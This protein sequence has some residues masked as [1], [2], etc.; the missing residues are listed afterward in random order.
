MQSK[1]A[2][3]KKELE[4]LR[5]Q[6]AEHRVETQ[7]LQRELEAQAATFDRQVQQTQQAA[8]LQVAG[9]QS[10]LNDIQHELAQVQRQ[11]GELEDKLEARTTPFVSTAATQTTA[12]VMTGEAWRRYLKKL[13]ETCM[14]HVH[15]RCESWSSAITAALADLPHLDTNQS[16]TSRHAH[17]R[18][19]FRSTRYRRDKELRAAV[20]S[21]GRDIKA[22]LKGNKA[23]TA[24]HGRERAFGP[25]HAD[26]SQLQA[27]VAEF[28]EHM[29][30]CLKQLQASNQPMDAERWSQ[31]E[32]KLLTCMSGPLPPTTTSP[33][34]PT[35]PTP[36]SPDALTTEAKTAALSAIGVEERRMLGSVLRTAAVNRACMS[37][38][39]DG[40]ECLW[41]GVLDLVACLGSGLVE[42][43]HTSMPAGH[44]QPPSLQ[45]G[46]YAVYKGIS[47]VWL[48]LK[49][50]LRSIQETAAAPASSAVTNMTLFDNNDTQDVE[51]QVHELLQTWSA[52]IAQYTASQQQE[53]RCDAG[54]QTSPWQPRMPACKP[55]SELKAKLAAADKECQGLIDKHAKAQQTIKSLE[56]RLHNK[57]EIAGQY[58]S[59]IASLEDERQKLE[60]EREKL[61]SQFEQVRR[62]QQLQQLKVDHAVRE[63]E[64]HVADAARLAQAEADVVDYK[65]KLQSVSSRCKQSEQQVVNLQHQLAELQTDLDDNMQQQHKHKQDL[66]H[67]ER[68]AAKTEQQLKTAEEQL[69]ILRKQLQEATQALEDARA[70]N[71]DLQRRHDA[72][73]L[74]HDDLSAHLQ[75]ATF[76]QQPEHASVNL[77]SQAS[78]RANLLQ[79]QPESQLLHPA[80]NAPLHRTLPE[81]F[82]SRPQL[83][84][85]SEVTTDLLIPLDDQRLL[86]GL[87]LSMHSLPS[88]ER[89][90][91]TTQ[92]DV[93]E[94]VRSLLGMEDDQL[95]ELMSS[96]H[97]N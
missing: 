27:W 65:R 29:A 41:Q 71:E 59:K 62:Q 22:T 66:A 97:E 82:P 77:P 12:D 91:A 44:D 54:V 75:R 26:S 18:R 20:V 9:L 8:V 68:Q 74:K 45:H 4:S 85:L 34:I 13:T 89:S 78:L 7:R 70:R 15:K 14:Q 73:K 2:E 30:A 95:T 83:D 76:T 90:T 57:G 47:L 60:L 3:M 43:A 37:Q 53:Q 24:S 33:S 1:E 84:A 50:E 21:L 35:T 16:A 88:S 81:S 39:Q 96:L 67:V 63:T 61:K 79:P 87:H 38:Q 94:R 42:M 52:S 10:S 56:Q 5:A 6:A 11:K 80:D 92:F 93:S 86:P 51:A 28:K 55:C 25:K 32:A 46:L 64:A 69:E 49:S 72:I 23:S 17:L 58:K 48:D 19:P 31:L 40:D 36:T